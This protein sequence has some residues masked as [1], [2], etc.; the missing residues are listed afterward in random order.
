MYESKRD[1]KLWDYRV[2]HG[3]LLLRSPMSPDLNT[4]VDL[5]FWGVE[6]VRLPTVMHGIRLRLANDDEKTSVAGRYAPECNGS[7]FSC[8]EDGA[9]IVIAAGCRVLENA[10]DIFESSL[11]SIH[12]PEDR[13]LGT[14]LAHCKK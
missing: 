6:F 8:D 3:Q 11:F 14:V 1:F 13:P 5:Q 12:D 4:N 9:A 10:M 7:V 2:S